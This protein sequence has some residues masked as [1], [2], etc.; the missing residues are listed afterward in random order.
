M[1]YFSV[2]ILSEI[3]CSVRISKSQKKFWISFLRADSDLR[4]YHLVL[5]SNFNLLHMLSYPT[6]KLDCNIDIGRY[7]KKSDKINK[8]SKRLQLQGEIREI[9]INKS[10]PR[11]ET[12][13]TLTLQQVCCQETHQ[14]HISSSPVQTT[15]LECLLIK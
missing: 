3:R 14:S 4:I 11:M 7:T 10:A 1:Y 8:K 9:R 2:N 6:L 15:W 5:C 13:T 12:Q